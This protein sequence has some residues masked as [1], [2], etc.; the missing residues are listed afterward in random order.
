M[1]GAE[2][3]Q[4]GPRESVSRE[5]KLKG[6]TRDAARLTPSSH[7]NTA[8]EREAAQDAAPLTAR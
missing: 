2:S 1:V 5:I 8:R 6:G 4:R 7:R 3:N